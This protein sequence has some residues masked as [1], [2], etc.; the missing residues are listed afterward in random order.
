M[1]L[2]LSLYLLLLSL[3]SLCQ[4]QNYDTIQI[5]YVGKWH[6][7]P[8]DGTGAGCNCSYSR[9]SGDYLEFTFTGS[10]VTW[11]GEKVPGHG[12]ALVELNGQ[13]DTVDQR[14]DILSPNNIKIP[15]YSKEVPY[16][17]YT[18][19]ITIISNYSVIH[20]FEVEKNHVEITYD[21]TKVKKEFKVFEDVLQIRKIENHYQLIKSDTVIDSIGFYDMTNLILQAEPFNENSFLVRVNRPAI[22]YFIDSDDPI[23]ELTDTQ[24][25]RSIAVTNDGIGIILSGE[26]KISRERR[27]YTV[28]L[29]KERYKNMYLI[30]ESNG[31]FSNLLNF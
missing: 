1:K 15:I 25:F 18:L 30:A 14:A 16:G 12:F 3:P 17:T 13:V 21:T 2:I 19:R 24:L 6:V 4:V 7:P 10:K 8:I 28:R 20:S 26:F 5:S 27:F 9:I 29:S 31:E 22:I 23:P 11:I